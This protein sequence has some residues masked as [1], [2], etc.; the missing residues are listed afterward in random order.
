MSIV[1]SVNS[2]YSLVVLF[3]G[4]RERSYCVEDVLECFA[5][6]PYKSY[7][8]FFFVILRWIVVVVVVAACIIYDLCTNSLTSSNNVFQF[9][10]TLFFFSNRHTNEQ[11]FENIQYYTQ[12]QWILVGYNWHGLAPNGNAKRSDSRLCS[13]LHIANDSSRRR[14]KS[15]CITHN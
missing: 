7:P 1:D 14:Q 11:C 8:Y 6:K 5:D 9:F 13:R 4:G 10:S 12:S 2:C 15:V 3:G